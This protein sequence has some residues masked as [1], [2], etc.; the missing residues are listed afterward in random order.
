MGDVTNSSS[1]SAAFDGV[2]LGI[3]R[4]ELT[5]N[6]DVIY[7]TPYFL[8]VIDASPNGLFYYIPVVL[9]FCTH[10]P[11][12]LRWTSNGGV[13][14]GHCRGRV[15]WPWRWPFR[16]PLLKVPLLENELGHSYRYLIRYLQ[17]ST[18][19]FLR[20]FKVRCQQKW[21]HIHSPETPSDLGPFS[22][23]STGKVRDHQN[24]GEWIRW[25]ELLLDD[26]WRS[27]K[28]SLC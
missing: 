21:Y 3:S 15:L 16:K 6:D 10:S 26:R 12:F 20:K 11:G 13:H 4:E 2:R 25:T 22:L 7:I 5:A 1:L 17:I 27:M 24:W 14:A 8:P 19:G 28:H 23:F 9:V 18:D